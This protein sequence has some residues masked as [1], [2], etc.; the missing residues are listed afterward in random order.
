VPGPWAPGSQAPRGYHRDRAPSTPCCH[1]AKRPVHLAERPAQPPDSHQCPSSCLAHTYAYL[2][3]YT[4]LP[5][6]ASARAQNVLRSAQGDETLKT[7]E[8]VRR[9]LRALDMHLA[10]AL[11]GVLAITAGGYYG[12]RSLGLEGSVAS[13]LGEPSGTSE[14][15]RAISLAP[16]V[17]GI[18]ASFVGLYVVL[19]RLSALM[20]LAQECPTLPARVASQFRLM[21]LSIVV[22]FHIFP[23]VWLLAALQLISIETEKLG[24][25]VGDLGA[26]YIILF[27]YTLT[28]R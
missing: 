14:V 12:S 23:A 6:F 3:T 1:L 15:S 20:S 28:V 9:A 10:H 8:Q 18:I 13:L 16:N 27:V 25:T 26:K 11:L 2:P 22:T 17:A 4:S 19:Q 7:D 5:R 24:Y 21:R